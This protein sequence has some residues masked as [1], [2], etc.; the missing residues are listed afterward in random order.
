[1][2]NILKNTLIFLSVLLLSIG[3]VSCDKDEG[4]LSSNYSTS[5]IGKWIVTVDENTDV[6]IVTFNSDKTA[7]IV[8]YKDFEANGLSKK[9]EECNVTWNVEKDKITF[10]GG[11]AWFAFGYTPVTIVSVSSNSIIG[12]QWFKDSNVKFTRM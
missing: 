11:K 10:D 6:Y 12:S 8:Q 2:K 1:M 3:F 4:V 5:L 7:L 9:G